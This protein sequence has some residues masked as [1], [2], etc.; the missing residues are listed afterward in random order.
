MFVHLFFN[1]QVNRKQF[2]FKFELLIVHS[3]VENAEQED[4]VIGQQHKVSWCEMSASDRGGYVLVVYEPAVEQT[5]GKKKVC[6]ILQFILLFL[7]VVSMLLH[8]IFTG[9]ERVL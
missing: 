2:E 7:L 3:V 4:Q 9:E 6:F 8:F 1:L 5:A